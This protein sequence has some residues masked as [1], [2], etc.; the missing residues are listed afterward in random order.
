V[1]FEGLKTACSKELCRTELHG[2]NYTLR[3][4]NAL[5]TVENSFSE[6]DRLPD[7]LPSALGLQFVEVLDCFRRIRLA[8]FLLRNRAQQTELIERKAGTNP[9]QPNG[10]ESKNN[11]GGRG[12]IFL[13]FPFHR[14]NRELGERWGRTSV[15][16]GSWSSGRKTGNYL[17]QGEES[18]LVSKFPEKIAAVRLN[19]LP[20][21]GQEYYGPGQ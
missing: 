1:C 11:S 2:T 7:V 3:R 4:W 8:R 17:I 5:P 18:K 9:D 12:T 14:T 21:D 10:L 16:G 19:P 6:T 20:V 15:G 13:D